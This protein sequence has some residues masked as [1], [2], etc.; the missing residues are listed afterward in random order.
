LSLARSGTT[1][2]LRTSASLDAGT[3]KWEMDMRM[4]RALRSMI[5][6]ISLAALSALSF[7]TVVLGASTGGDW[8]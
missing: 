2:P 5:L 8:P 4:H 7:V 3:A 6:A 1:F